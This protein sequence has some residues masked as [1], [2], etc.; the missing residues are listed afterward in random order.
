MDIRECAHHSCVLLLHG[1]RL[2][3]PTEQTSIA[4]GVEVPAMP[5]KHELIVHE[6]QLT[7]K[8]GQLICWWQPWSNNKWSRTI[9][10]HIN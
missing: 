5:L 7:L 9:S 10:K 4:L 6:Q 3:D 8:N 1:C 2:H